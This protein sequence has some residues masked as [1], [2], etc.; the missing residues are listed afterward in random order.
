MYEVQATG[1]FLKHKSAIIVYVVCIG[2]EK[3]VTVSCHYG[4][5]MINIMH[6]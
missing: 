5:K 4:L 2:R 1:L 6:P 3:Q